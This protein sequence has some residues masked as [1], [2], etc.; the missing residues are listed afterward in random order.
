MKIQKS[1]SIS[2]DRI[3]L[4]LL[5]L[6]QTDAAQSQQSLAQQVH[7]SPPTCLR[8]VQR[9]Q[10]AGLIERQVAI[11]EPE[12]LAAIQGH[13]LACIVEVSLERQGAESLDAF[14]AR[15]VADA[16]VQQCWR[17]SP[18]PDFVLVL[19]VRDMPGYLS[20]AQRLFTGDA[21]VR[22]VRAFFATRRAKFSTRV[23]LLHA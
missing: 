4:Q 12:R 2:L 3:D 8:R 23:P 6:L 17:V 19:H 7:V 15:A 14:E 21:N 16:A 1:K 13:G 22:N 5:D 10:A 18:G 11:L 9:L 20:L